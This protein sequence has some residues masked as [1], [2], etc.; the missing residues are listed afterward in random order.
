LRRRR[1]KTQR[2]EDALEFGVR[3]TCNNSPFIVVDESLDD[4]FS[5]FADMQGKL[6]G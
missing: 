3:W 4:L 1:N 5:S 6:V 2:T